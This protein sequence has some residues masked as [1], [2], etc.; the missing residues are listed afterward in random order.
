MLEE[1]KSS[2]LAEEII[3]QLENPRKSIEKHQN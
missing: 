2:I 1:T 3:M